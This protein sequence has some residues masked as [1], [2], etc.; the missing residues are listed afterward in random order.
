MGLYCDRSGAGECE[1]SEPV[2]RQQKR[3]RHAEQEA[4]ERLERQAD[5]CAKLTA[6][7]VVGLGAYGIWCGINAGANAL[8]LGAQD[9]RL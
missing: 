2:V 5:R 1:S 6:V 8:T 7:G 9:D 4:E 3:R